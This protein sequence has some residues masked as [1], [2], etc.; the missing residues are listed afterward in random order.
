V[1]GNL[2]PRE[3]A[4]CEEIVRRRRLKKRVA[5]ALHVKQRAF[6]CDSCKRLAAQA[7][8]RAGKSTGLAGRFFLTAI[9]NPTECS[10]FI[11]IS[12]ARANEIIGTAL[13][14]IGKAI[15]W[16]PKPTSRAG[17]L[18]WIFPNGHKLW[19]AGC[20][21]KAD[22]EKFR[23]SRY[24]G[25]AVDE[26]DSM[27]RHLQYLVEDILDPA[28]MDLDGWL[29]LTGTPGVTPTGYFHAITTG[30][31]KIQSW[32]TYHWTALD[33]P[34][35]KDPAGY[36]RRRREALGLSETSP[37]YRREWL[38]EWVLDLE[39]LCYPYDAA[40]NAIEGPLTGHDWRYVLAIDL[41]VVDDTAFALLAYRARDPVIRV[42]ETRTYHNSTPSSIGLRVGEWRARYP[43]ARIIADTGGIG[44]GFTAEW[45]ARYGIFC[46]P[47]HKADCA[48]QIVLTGDLIRTGALK[49]HLPGCDTL[50]RQWCVL[51]WN[52]DR[53]GHD[54]AY[55]DHESD[56]VRYGVMAIRPLITVASVDEPPPGTPAFEQRQEAARR[57]AVFAN[58]G[59]PQRRR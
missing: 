55:E 9:D 37:T 4:I 43:G 19:V 16:E 27:R 20:K 15:D 3:R 7:G 48:A 38:G 18:Y 49:I 32:P 54:P 56:A 6:A 39:S 33:N 24:A 28:L 40:R 14:T 13:R 21:N 5:E 12:A 41:G 42:V 8:R 57:A 36:L 34:F 51:P 45:A 35:L 2:G 46:E 10:V 23:G 59:K 47:A 17:Q 50:A 58:A 30:E 53:T 22:A 44:K 25:A 11:A 29:A 31:D 1:T 26:C 52:P